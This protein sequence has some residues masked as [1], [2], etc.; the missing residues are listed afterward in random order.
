MSLT[1]RID[2]HG[3]AWFWVKVTGNIG[4]AIFHAPVDTGATYVILSEPSCT[5][6]GLLRHPRG[7]RVTLR[8]VTGDTV[9]RIFIAKSVSI[10]GSDIRLENIEIAA[11]S[12]PG[13]PM[14]LGMS[15]LKNLN[16]SFNKQRQEFT[17]SP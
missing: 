7:Q 8:T 12:V 5:N 13:F 1:V 2:E 3:L 6:L 11:K 9:A 15:F 17:I 16:W 14:I 10:E 4:S